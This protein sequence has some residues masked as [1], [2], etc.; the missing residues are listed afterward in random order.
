MLVNIWRNFNDEIRCKSKP[1]YFIYQDNSYVDVYFEKGFK[2]GIDSSEPKSKIWHC[3]KHKGELRRCIEI[4]RSQ[5]TFNGH[6]A[7]IRK[8]GE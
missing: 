6:A 4:D 7:Y 1:V 3:G 8:K 2:A 5:V